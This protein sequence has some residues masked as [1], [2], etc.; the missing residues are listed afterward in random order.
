M[1]NRSVHCLVSQNIIGDNDPGNEI[2]TNNVG[3]II[4]GG[5]Y[6][7]TIYLKYVL[8]KLNFEFFFTT[9]NTMKICAVQNIF[10]IVPVTAIQRIQWLY[11]YER[12]NSSQFIF[13]T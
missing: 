6:R 10:S 12:H 7:T 9:N 8:L 1:Q 11:F 13:G 3:Q 2:F 4:F 5:K